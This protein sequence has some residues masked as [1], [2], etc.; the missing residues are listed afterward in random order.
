M[1]RSV[2]IVEDAREVASLLEVIVR[3]AATYVTVRISDFHNTIDDVDWD[4]FDV[5]ITDRC[6][7]DYD[8]ADLLA[9]LE[10]NHPSI[11][12]IMLTGDTTTDF[13]LCHAHVLFS[14]PVSADRLNHHVESSL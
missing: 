13:D 12:R 5:V 6:L 2:L 9:F 4:D 11:K 14:K 10:A 3:K 8:G 7:D 1:R